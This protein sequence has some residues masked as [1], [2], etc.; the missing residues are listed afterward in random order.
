MQGQ[1]PP[2]PPYYGGVNPYNNPTMNPGPNMQ[3]QFGVPPPFNP[4]QYNFNPNSHAM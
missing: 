1:Y 2:Q 3:G 4:G